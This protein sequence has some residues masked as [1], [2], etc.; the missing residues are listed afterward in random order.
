MGEAPPSKLKIE[1]EIE[2]HDAINNSLDVDAIT[3]E[4]RALIRYLAS[5]DIPS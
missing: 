5:V 3:K 1:E 4:L 2:K